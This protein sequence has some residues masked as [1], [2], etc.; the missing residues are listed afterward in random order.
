MVFKN[1]QRAYQTVF[2]TA[3]EINDRM[4][5]CKACDKFTEKQFCKECGC[6]MPAKTTI[7]RFKCPLGKW[8][9]VS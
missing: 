5:T 2:L 6:F 8:K 9:N 3:N 4:N 7:R 1:W